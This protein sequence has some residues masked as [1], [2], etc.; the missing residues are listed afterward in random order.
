[1]KRS[2]LGINSVSTGHKTLEEGLDAYAAAG[3]TNVEFALGQLEGKSAGEVRRALQERGLNILGGFFCELQAFSDDEAR[4][5]N[6]KVLLEKARFLSEVAQGAPQNMVVGTDYRPIGELDSPLER[7]GEAFGEVAGQVAPL[8]VTLCLE[9]NWGAVKTLQSAVEIARLSGASNVGVLFDPAHYHCTPTKFEHLSPQNVPFI[10]HVHLD[11]MRPK[12]GELSDCNSDREL[13]GHGHLDLRAL[14]GAIEAG[15]Y[16]G[17][18]S[19][20]MFSDDLWKL[21]AEEAAK[22]MYESLLPFCED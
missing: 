2:Q 16:Q 15:G 14:I 17:A 13:P 10:K 4:A 12:P 20:E 22:Q 9:F 5:A 19:I 6:R 11:D 1:M 7:Y 8:G 18:F 3:F 21:P